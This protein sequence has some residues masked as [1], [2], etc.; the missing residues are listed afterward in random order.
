MNDLLNGLLLS[1]ALMITVAAYLAVWK[2]LFG[3]RVEAARGALEATP[4]RV[5]VIGFNVLF[6]GLIIVLLMSQLIE[7]TGAGV[8]W[9]PVLALLGVLALLLSTGLSAVGARIGA[10]ALPAHSPLR[11]ILVGGVLLYWA[12]L[13]PFVGWFLLLPFLACMGIGAGLLAMRRETPPPGARQ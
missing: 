9:L 2:L 3:A 11:Q 5:F 7:A 1:L 10:R 12:A 13:L 4:V 6:F 8:L